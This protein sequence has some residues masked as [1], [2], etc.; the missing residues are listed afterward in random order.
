M[1]YLSSSEYGVTDKANY[2]HGNMTMAHGTI[3]Y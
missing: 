3:I 2:L 1:V